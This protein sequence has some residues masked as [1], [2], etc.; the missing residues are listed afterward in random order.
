L[1][2]LF[3]DPAGNPQAQEFAARILSQRMDAA[4]LDRMVAELNNHRLSSDA[5]SRLAMILDGMPDVR[6]SLPGALYS[7]NVGNVTRFREYAVPMLRDM[8]REGVDLTAIETAWASLDAMDA[9]TVGDVKY[10]LASPYLYPRAGVVEYLLGENMDPAA[11]FHTSNE[12]IEQVYRQRFMDAVQ[13]RDW[14]GCLA[15]YQQLCIVP[16][17]SLINMLITCAAGAVATACRYFVVFLRFTVER[18]T[19]LGTYMFRLFDREA[20]SRWFMISGFFCS[21]RC[22]YWRSP[23]VGIWYTVPAYLAAVV[24]ARLPS[25]VFFLQHIRDYTYLRRFI[26]REWDLLSPRARAVAVKAFLNSLRMRLLS[27]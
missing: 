14:A 15:A 6:A 26:S 27:A 11:A 19:F 13:D 5:H 25:A 12:Q 3:D 23:G 8:V 4:S 1:F 24:I 17:Y 9:V 7:G 18:M 16:A 2:T 20:G 22:R 21:G 10:A